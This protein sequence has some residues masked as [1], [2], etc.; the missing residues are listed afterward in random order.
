MEKEKEKTADVTASAKG[1]ASKRQGERNEAEGIRVSLVM[2]NRLM[3]ETLMHVLRRRGDLQLGVCCGPT[4]D[5]LKEI[6]GS[7]SDVV[8]VDLVTADFLAALAGEKRGAHGGTKVIAIGMEPNRD[9][10]LTAVRWGVS[11]YLLKDAGANEVVAAVRTVKR[12]EAFCSPQ[13]CKVLFEAVA[14]LKS[15]LPAKKRPPRKAGLTL[16]Q[17]MLMRLVAKGLTNKEIAAQLKLSEFTVRNHVSRVLKQLHAETRSAAV[18][19]MR[20][21]LHELSA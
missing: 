15:E 16:R 4:K 19:T 18:D 11:G 14:E 3:R 21:S 6:T 2:M 7:E 12:G 20:E 13:M 5:E 8:L 1:V 17:Q 9:I 10:F